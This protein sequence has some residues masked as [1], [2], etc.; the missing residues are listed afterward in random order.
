MIN[1]FWQHGKKEIVSPSH[2][3]H[4]YL[5]SLVFIAFVAFTVIVSVVTLNG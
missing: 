1:K 4:L 2:S 5:M 3:N